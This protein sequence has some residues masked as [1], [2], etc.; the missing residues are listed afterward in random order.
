VAL[1][2]AEPNVYR[3]RLRGLIGAPA[4]RN[5]SCNL[6]RVLGFRFAPLERGGMSE[7]GGPID[8]SSLRDEELAKTILLR[9]QEVVGLLRRLHRFSPGN[10]QETNFAR[11]AG[12]VRRHLRN[13]RMLSC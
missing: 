4:E 1:A 6:I 13:L 5:V 11:L 7:A 8:I 12:C 3:H 9:K 10:M 2:P